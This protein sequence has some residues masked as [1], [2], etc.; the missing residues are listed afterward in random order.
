MG[1]IAI[2]GMEF[3]AIHGCMKEEQVTGNIHMYRE[4][5]DGGAAGVCVFN[6]LDGWWK[7]GD[8]YTHD[9]H[10]EE[11]FGLVEFDTDP[12]NRQGTT[13]PVWDSLKTY[14]MAIIKE[15]RNEALYVQKVPLEIYLQDTAKRLIV[16][17][18]K[19]ILKQKSHA[20][21]AG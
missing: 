12:G 7:G 10:P 3:H 2:E 18:G 19:E 15:P 5:L 20:S 9:D 17:N 4:L 13:R 16:R 8:E 6:Y 14:Q 21:V 1:T 11:W